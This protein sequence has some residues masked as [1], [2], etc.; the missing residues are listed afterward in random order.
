MAR[1]YILG[2]L[3]PVYV[4]EAAARG[5]ILVGAYLN[6][7]SA[8]PTVVNRYVNTD[9]TAG[10][11]GTTNA[12]AGANR[13]YATLNEAFTAMRSTAWAAN[14][15]Q[16]T[17]ICSG[18]VA[19]ATTST[20]T[21]T[22]LSFDCYLAIIGNAPNALQYDTNSYRIENATGTG[23]CLFNNGCPYLYVQSLQ[24]KHTISSA[25]GGRVTFNVLGPTSGWTIYDRCHAWGSIVNA[26]VNAVAAFSTSST[27]GD[28]HTLHVRNC[29]IH[30]YKAT[31]QVHVALVGQT[32]ATS[33]LHAY[34]NTVVN[35]GNGLVSNASNVLAKN[36]GVSGCTDG[37]S[38]TLIS[39]STN[40][41]S[42]LAADATGTN[43]RNSVTP[44]FVNVAGGDY[45]LDTTD[46]AWKD[47]GTDLSADAT[48]P[49]S[50]DGNGSTRSGTW[51][52]G[53]D[54]FVAAGPLDPL[55]MTGFFG[56]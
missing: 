8:A 13:A 3:S 17:I 32:V 38:G 46:T 7:T 12:T 42:D 21:W 44:V 28:T 53:A 29:C 25:V 52:I 35:C 11:D 47:Q 4:A 51:D 33:R 1:Q 41:A 54:E 6:E 19:D 55:G 24:G 9:S 10:G 48:W 27:S 2:G 34:N 56:F 45:H 23:G 26:Q 20:G 30:D 31:G 37:Y 22:S 14:R 50:T 40:N 15:Q 39:G 36:N 43:A 49:F 16:P 18:T 5:E